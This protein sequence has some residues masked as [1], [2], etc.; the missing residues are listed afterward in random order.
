MLDRNAETLLLF[1]WVKCSF[2]LLQPRSTSRCGRLFLDA[3]AFAAKALAAK[4]LAAKAL[5]AKELAV[6]AHS[7][8]YVFFKCFH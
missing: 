4:A 2:A 5:A 8:F 1:C 3:K 7:N 6:K